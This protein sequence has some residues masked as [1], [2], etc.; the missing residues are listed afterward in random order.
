MT[1]E[2]RASIPRVRFASI[3]DAILGTT[4]TLNLVFTTPTAIQ[5]LNKIYRNKNTPADI[6]SFPL[7]DTEGEIYI[8]PSETRKEAKNFDRDYDNFMAFLFIHGCVH[9]KGHDHGGTMEDIEIN[10]RKKFKI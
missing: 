10:F 2:T 7:S 8:S 6:L 4:Y 1:N 5:K 3:K 9:L